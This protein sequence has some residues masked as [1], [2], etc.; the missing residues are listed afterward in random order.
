MHLDFYGQ[1]LGDF[2]IFHKRQAAPLKR[3]ILNLL[4]LPGVARYLLVLE[5]HAMIIMNE[6]R[7][8]SAVHQFSNEIPIFSESRHL[9]VRGRDKAM[10]C[11]NR[12]NAPHSDYSVHAMVIDNIGQIKKPDQVVLTQIYQT[13]SMTRLRNNRILIIGI[14]LQVEKFKYVLIR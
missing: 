12:K 1:W 10:I 14:P 11:Y 9:F 2:R 7:S 8:S 5:G 4:P 3:K 13:V 6:P